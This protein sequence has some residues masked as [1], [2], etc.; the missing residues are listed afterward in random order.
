[1]INAINTALSPSVRPFYTIIPSPPL[2]L[3]LPPTPP[4]PPAAEEEEEEGGGDCWEKRGAWVW[5]TRSSCGGLTTSCGVRPSRVAA[6]SR[7]GLAEERKSK[8]T[9]RKT[10]KSQC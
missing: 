10:I 1:M 3:A 7:V 5:A 4:P 8:P 9:D 2:P 6:I